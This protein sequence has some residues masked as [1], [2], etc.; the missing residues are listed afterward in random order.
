MP[1]FPARCEH[2]VCRKPGIALV[3]FCLLVTSGCYHVRVIV[4]K[5]D[6]STEYKKQTVQN[7]AWG[8]LPKK[9][10]IPTT[11]CRNNTSIDEVRTSSNLGFSVLTVATIGFW[12]PSQV[13]W[14]CS[15]PHEKPGTIHRPKPASLA[16]TVPPQQAAAGAPRSGRQTIHTLGWGL[17]A[18]NAVAN[19]CADSNAMDEVRVS[20]NLGYHVLTVATLGFWSPTTVEWKCTKPQEQSVSSN[21]SF[22][23]QN[24][25]RLDAR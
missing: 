10:D 20:S 7:L 23:I 14:R 2:G 24:Q 9:S 18:E 17:V 6:P 22:F 21:P 5:P 12:S 19:N 8:A 15:K 4:P 16:L 1:H 3:F 11:D 25:T 13:E